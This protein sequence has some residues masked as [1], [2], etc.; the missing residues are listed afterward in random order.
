MELFKENMYLLIINRLFLS[1]SAIKKK[2]VYV[3]S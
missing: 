3:H 1:D 2:Y